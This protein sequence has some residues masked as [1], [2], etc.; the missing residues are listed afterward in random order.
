MTIVETSVRF[1]LDVRR[2]IASLQRAAESLHHLPKALQRCQEWSAG[3]SSAPMATRSSGTPRGLDDRRIERDEFAQALAEAK[4]LLAESEPRLVRLS[5]LA[6]RY[7]LDHWPDADEGD[8]EG[9]VRCCASCE[10]HGVFVEVPD[11]REH[12]SWCHQL[13]R[14][15]GQW[16]TRDLVLRHARGGRIS[17]RML[18]DAFGQRTAA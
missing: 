6:Q 3:I 10:A 18:D 7:G 11:D 1:D 2:A 4:R 16:P 8:T 12:C 9:A 17:Q 5:A 13:H 14:A 15:V